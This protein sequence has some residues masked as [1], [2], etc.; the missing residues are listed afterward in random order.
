MVSPILPDVLKT[1]GGGVV[2][3]VVGGLFVH[4]LTKRR[5]SE[6][7]RRAFQG[8][9]RAIVYQFQELDLLTIQKGQM[10]TLKQSTVTDLRNQ[11]ARIYTDIKPSMRNRFE[12]SWWIYIRYGDKDVEPF[13]DYIPGRG[14]EPKL[15]FP[16]YERGRKQTLELL[17]ELIEC[18]K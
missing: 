4:N 14:E 15:L 11:C 2:G 10:L 7:R 12:K 18:T 17:N 1:V 3:A 13:D 9:I 16:N 6:S 5:E 8:F